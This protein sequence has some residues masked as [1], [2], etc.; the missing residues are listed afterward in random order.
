MLVPRFGEESREGAGPP[1]HPYPGDR[2]Q[3]L[4]KLAEKSKLAGHP[5]LNRG[6]SETA[7]QLP[8]IVEYL[9]Q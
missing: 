6:D 4:A 5:G 8:H 2:S 3:S 7:L 9:D 1:G